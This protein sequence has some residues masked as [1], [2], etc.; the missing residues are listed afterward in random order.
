MGRPR[1]RGR[2]RLRKDG[3]GHDE[4]PASREKNR[5]FARSGRL[6]GRKPAEKRQC[7]SG[8]FAEIPCNTEQGI[9]WERAGKSETLTG[10]FSAAG[11]EPGFNQEL[12]LRKGLGRGL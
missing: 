7:F 12:P 9:F 11:L 10:N 6:S 3:S 5:E 4:F 2:D 1:L 8:L